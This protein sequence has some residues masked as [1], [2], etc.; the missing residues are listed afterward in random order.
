MNKIELT[1]PKCH[2]NMKLSDDGSQAHCEYCDYCFL[3]QKDESLE[4]AYE[5]VHKLAYA[6]ADG[7]NRANEDSE[8]RKL[9]KKIK[10]ILLVAALLILLIVV[11]IM[12]SFF[13]K[14]LIKDPFDNITLSF[15]GENTK[16]EVTI[17]YKEK[18]SEIEYRVSK[19]KNLT[20]GE[21]IIVYVTSKKYRF[22]EYEKEYKVT[23]LMKQITSLDEITDNIKTYLNNSSYE[24]QKNK[25]ETG[26]SF[27]GKILKLKPYAMYLGKTETSNVIFDIFTVKIETNSNNSF[28][29]YVVTAYSNVILTKDEENPVKYNDTDNIGGMILAG[30]PN[31]LNAFDGNYAG[32]IHGFER[33]SGLDNYIIEEYDKSMKVYKE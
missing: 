2:A 22:S 8:K 12:V 13:S 27:K 31:S 10:T 19:D 17:N 26:Y 6:E 33:L 28:I 30:D 25:I 14:E 4:S 9:S 23:G 32:Y 21:T 7:R 11:V 29:K 24:F 16:G 15:Y 5:R 20:E 1:C 3:V 18:N